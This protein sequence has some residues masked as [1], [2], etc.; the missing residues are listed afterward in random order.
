MVN[1]T[2]LQLLSSLF[3]KQSCWRIDPL[4]AEMEYSVPSVRRFLA[5]DGLWFFSDIGFSRAGSLTKT[6]VELASK[7][8]KGMTAEELGD[9]LHCHCHE[10]LFVLARDGKLK[11]LKMGRSYIYIAADPN[12]AD[13]QRKAAASS[14]VQ[15]PAEIAVLILVEFIKNPGSSFT[16]LAKAISKS[17]KVTVSAAQIETLFAQYG[18]KKTLLT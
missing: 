4:A 17:K 14:N 16:Q 2:S 6:I 10:V 12:I 15:L 8:P 7:S 3:E 5:R 1:V 18:L 11:R 13:I 9:K